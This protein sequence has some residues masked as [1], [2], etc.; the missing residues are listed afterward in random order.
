M[1][2][3]LSISSWSL[4]R[5]LGSVFHNLDGSTTENGDISLLELPAKI[6][7]RGIKTLE[8]CHF[9]FPQIDDGYIDNVTFLV[10]G[11][12][13]GWFDFIIATIA[14]GR[15]YYLAYNYETIARRG[16]WAENID[17]FV[18]VIFCIFI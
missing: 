7:E 11:A 18:G 15:S 3:R 16:G 14:A 9:H 2:A 17:I 8:I 13:T 12:P 1:S 5:A 10:S 6:A 4:H